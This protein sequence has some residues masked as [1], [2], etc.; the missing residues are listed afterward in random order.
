MSWNTKVFVDSDR[1]GGHGVCTSPGPRSSP[2]NDDGYA[3]VRRPDA[4]AEFEDAIRAAAQVCPEWV[5]EAR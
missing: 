1:C 3:E 2:L 5:I 4:P